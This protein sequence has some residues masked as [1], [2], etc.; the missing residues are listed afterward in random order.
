MS[1]VT[2]LGLCTDNLITVLQPA[3]SVQCLLS[4]EPTITTTAGTYT[5]NTINVYPLGAYSGLITGY[6]S[7]SAVTTGV[8]AATLQLSAPVWASTLFI[9]ANQPATTIACPFS[10]IGD[11]STISITVSD[12]GITAGSYSVFIMVSSSG[13]C[14][15]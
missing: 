7:I 14:G 6:I 10:M 11:G 5:A 12:T 3:P 13:C 9:P 2:I 15:C 8:T 1:D 4:C